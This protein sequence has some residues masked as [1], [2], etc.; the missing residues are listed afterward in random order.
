[1]DCP[2]CH[3]PNV[4]GARF[5]AKCGALLPAAGSEKDSLLGQIVGGRYRITQMLGEGGMGRVYLAEQQM[6]TNVRKVAVKTLQAQY[7]KDQQVLA[8]FHR[9]CGTVSELEHPNTIH[10]F[11]FGQ[12]PDGQLYIAMEY[13]QGQSLSDALHQGPMRPDRVLKI[14]AQVCGSL[15]EAHR[16]GIVHR[17]LKPDNVILTNRAGQADFV[18]VLDFGI[19]KRSEAKDQAQEQKLTQQGMVLGTPP[20]MSPEQFTGKEL[21]P[22]S[23]IYSL[24][25]MAYEMLTGRLPFDADTPWQWATQHM[26]AQP[27]PFEQVAAAA[28]AGIPGPMKQAILRALSKDRTQR[29]AEVRQFYGELA[30]GGTGM[31]TSPVL[32]VAPH[33]GQGQQH[34]AWVTP[35]PVAAHSQPGGSNPPYTPPGQMAYTPPPPH[36]AHATPAGGQTFPTSP[37]PQ[38]YG[39]PPARTGGGKGLLI[40]VLAIGAV[41]AIVAVVLVV[42]QMGSQD[43]STTASTANPT[44]TQV[45]TANPTPGIPD[46]I[47]LPTATEADAGK[48]APGV[49]TARKPPPATSAAP[50]AS[51]PPP[52]PPPT[53]TGDAACAEAKRQG[54]NGDAAAAARVFAG[55]TGPGAAAARAAIVRGAPDAVKR[56]IFNGDCAGARALVA[57]LTAIGAAG[58]A[59]AVI[60]AAPQ[61]K[62]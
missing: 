16:R 22:R 35:P 44:A 28:A 3:Q 59:Q 46:K 58:G 49:V 19:A 61:C 32:P 34:P 48:V 40:A 15:E 11:D 29:Q 50:S 36:V 55:C 47:A 4:D 20:Y 39:S 6:G 13:A 54:E 24:A 31:G 7:A 10:F 27:F 42:R 21:D 53:L 8:R 17:D 38:A 60:D 18:K 37:Q 52:P 45:A 57:A 56:R 23:D 25:V 33:T 26:T 30:S 1:M 14:L 43:D 51:T 62:K 12:T 5:C 9:E 2:A 41:V